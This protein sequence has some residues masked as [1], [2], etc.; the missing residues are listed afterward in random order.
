MK[1]AILS[2]AALAILFAVLILVGTGRWSLSTAQ[3]HQDR[4]Q[5]QNGDR[6]LGRLIADLT[7]RTDARS[8]ERTLPDGGV[9]VDM[10]K[11]F[12]NV[13]LGRLG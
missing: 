3:T 7:D 13:M 9:E 6:E 12:Q 5:P 4:A 1:K 8:I 2:A 10:G 11:T